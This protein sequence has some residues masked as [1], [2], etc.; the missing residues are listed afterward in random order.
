MS[1]HT[2][3]Q[4]LQPAVEPVTL[5]YVK[6]SLGIPLDLAEDDLLLMGLVSASRRMAEVRL[7]KAI[8]ASK[9][10]AAIG[11]T[12]VTRCGCGPSNGCGPDLHPGMERLPRGPVLYGPDYP[13]AI[14]Q[15]TDAGDLEPLPVEEFSVHRLYGAVSV[16]SG[17]RRGMWVEWWAGAEDPADVPQTIKVAITMMVGI[18]YANRGDGTLEADLS[19]AW[20]AVAALVAAEFDGRIYA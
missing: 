18:L 3:T 1:T 11:R 10:R 13:A 4:V 15:E 5:A 17:W 6:Q 9:W 20:D 7:G 2:L 14:F 16:N 19:S 8:M 12:V